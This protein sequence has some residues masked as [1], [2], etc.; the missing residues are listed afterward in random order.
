MFLDKDAQKY[1]DKT[2]WIGMVQ[3]K[4]ELQQADGMHT[5][6]LMT[7]LRPDQISRLHRRLIP[8]S[9]GTLLRRVEIIPY[10]DDEMAERMRTALKVLRSQTKRSRN[11]ELDE[12][13]DSMSKR[14]KSNISVIALLCES[15]CIRE[16]SEVGSESFEGWNLS[17]GGR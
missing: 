15:N 16:P 1:G 3:A 4:D 9:A 14:S 11:E 5:I 17:W 8:Q 12:G 10:D 6:R 2:C 7:S 13:T